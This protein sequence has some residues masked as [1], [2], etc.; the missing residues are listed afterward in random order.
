MQA[1]AHRSKSCV[2]FDNQFHKEKGPSG[3][4]GIF[5][6]VR[7]KQSCKRMD[8]MNKYPSKSGR[9]LK[10]LYDFSIEIWQ[11]LA[12]YIGFI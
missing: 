5:F 10:Y 4:G 1:Q 6:D 12:F 7:E 11:I 2:D 3:T 8:N 9:K